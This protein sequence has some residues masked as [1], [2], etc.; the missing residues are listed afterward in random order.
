MKCISPVNFVARCRSLALIPRKEPVSRPSW[1]TEHKLRCRSG[2]IRGLSSMA[3]SER[4][5]VL[6]ASHQKDLDEAKVRASAV[7]EGEYWVGR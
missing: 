4:K 3:S 5:T 2:S 6:S 1:L 7:N